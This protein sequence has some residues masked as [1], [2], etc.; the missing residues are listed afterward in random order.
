MLDVK[1][2]ISIIVPVYNTESF[3]PACSSLLMPK[4]E[5]R[6]RLSLLTMAQLMGHLR[7]VTII[8]KGTKRPSQSTRITKAY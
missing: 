5:E 4:G 7:Y 8:A 6:M 1:P 3:L 2:D